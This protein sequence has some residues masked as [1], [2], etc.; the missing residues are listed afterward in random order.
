LIWLLRP[1]SLTSYWSWLILTTRLEMDACF[2]P[3]FGFTHSLGLRMF[4]MNFLLI[5][6][7]ESLRLNLC[8]LTVCSSS[9]N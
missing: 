3:C 8:L 7:R 6:L 9:R 5:C 4:S 2:L 1:S